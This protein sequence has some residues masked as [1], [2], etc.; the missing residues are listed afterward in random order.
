MHLLLIG[1]GGREHALAWKLAKSPAITRISI[2][3]GNPGTASEPKCTNVSI[4]VDDIDALLSFAQDNDV[5]LTVVGPEAP[6]VAGVSDAFVKAFYGRL[7]G[8]LNH[9]EYIAGD[10]FTVADISAFCCIEFA[11][12]LVGLKPDEQHEHLW[13]WHS[14]IA[15]RDSV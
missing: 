12:A 5:Q 10:R 11:G 15:A 4:A 3:P 8:Q 13:R 1:N 9:N 6:L 7:D 14:T 2:A